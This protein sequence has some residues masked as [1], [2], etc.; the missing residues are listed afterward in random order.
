MRQR[1][2]T[3]AFNI[4]APGYPFYIRSSTALEDMSNVYTNGVSESGKDVGVVIWHVGLDA[5]DTLW[6]TTQSDANFTGQIVVSDIAAGP[7]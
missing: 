7:E 1:G 6:Y 3:Y 4:Q 2:V 5:P